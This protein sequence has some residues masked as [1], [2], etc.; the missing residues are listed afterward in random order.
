M[1]HEPSMMQNATR[2][3]SCKINSRVVAKDTALPERRVRLLRRNERGTC[4]SDAS[5]DDAM[6]RI[7]DDEGFYLRLSLGWFRSFASSV[8]TRPA[9]VTAWATRTDRGRGLALG[10]DR[11]RAEGVRWRETMWRRREIVVVNAFH[12]ESGSVVVEQ[13]RV[14]GGGRRTSWMMRGVVK[15]LGLGLWERARGEDVWRR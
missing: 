3:T 7:R 5:D 11:A 8:V 15:A 4:A 2:F 10:R 6:T 13:T 12:V 9:R 14:G 1:N